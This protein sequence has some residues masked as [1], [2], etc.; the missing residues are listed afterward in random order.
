MTPKN[1]KAQNDEFQ[2]NLHELEKINSCSSR[3]V[4]TDPGARF[5]VAKRV[6][7]KEVRCYVS[8]KY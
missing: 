5:E 1:I 4:L 2:T 7:L 3:A 8:L 6:S